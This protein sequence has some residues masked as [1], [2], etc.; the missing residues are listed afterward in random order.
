MLVIY[1]V[2]YLILKNFLCLSKNKFVGASVQPAMLIV[3]E[4][5]RDGNLHKHLSS[6]RP[7][8]LDLKLSIGFALDIAGAMEYL[9]ANNII[10]R[11]LKPSTRSFHSF[12]AI[13]HLVFLSEF[14]SRTSARPSPIFLGLNS[15]CRQRGLAFEYVPA[16]YIY[17]H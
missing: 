14:V 3:T 11:D 16:I 7:Q 10:H 4:L 5:L 17:C 1:L 6:L 12:S 15:G 2:I 8:P 9:H 13:F